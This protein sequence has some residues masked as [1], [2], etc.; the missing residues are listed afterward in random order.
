[1]LAVTIRKRL[2]GFHLDAAFEGAAEGVTI[3]FGPSG[4]GKSSVLAAV[5]GALRPDAGRITLGGQP[6]FDAAARID[7]PMERRRIGWVFQDARLFP[8]LSVDANLRFGLRRAAPSDRPIRFDEVVGV[9]GVEPL[10]ARRPRDLSGGERQRV[11]LGRALL[12]QPRL[13]LMDEPLAALDAPRRAEILPFLER[14]KSQFGV[15]AL[16]V[17]HSLAEAIR[18]GD[19]MVVMREGRVVAQGSLGEIVS[20]PD[21]MLLGSRD[22]IGAALEGR[23]I[24]HEDRLTRVAVG[25]WTIRTARLDLGEGAPVRLFVQARD[26]MLA[27]DPPRRISA[28]NVLD[29]DIVGLE[30]DGDRVLAHVEHA[31]QRL[32]CALTQDAA[33]ELQLKPGLKVWAVVKSVAIDGLGGGLLESLEG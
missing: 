25:G 3:L 22:R 6:L 26:V 28:R 21:L 5:A 14:L 20:R 27:L 16:Y 2:G 7:A 10:L 30:A 18:L 8:H 19:R 23:V 31:G 32:I 1:M 9:L 4:A 15:P 33:D 17:T 11:G 29:G 12:S 24:G 13:L